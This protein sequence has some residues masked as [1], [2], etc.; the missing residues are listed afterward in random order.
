MKFISSSYNEET[1]K[2]VVIVQHLGKKFKGVAFVHPSDKEN[3]SSFAGCEYAEIRATIQALKY[4]RILMKKKADAA[5]EFVHACECYKNFIKDSK[6][7][8]VV[9]RQ[10]NRRIARV[11]KLADEINDLYRQLE[12]KQTKRE[13]IINAVKRYKT[14][15]AK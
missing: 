1:G 11:N 9:Y 4:E 12:Q 6:S 10:L 14:K 7:A 13:I 8:K 3:A 2:S 5:I 15:K